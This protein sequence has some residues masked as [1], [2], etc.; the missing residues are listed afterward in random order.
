MNKK[1][2]Y[3]HAYGKKRRHSFRADFKKLAYLCYKNEGSNKGVNNKITAN[4]KINTF[5]YM[6]QEKRERNYSIYRALLE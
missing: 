5:G 1:I 6:Y 3:L 2:S 4:R